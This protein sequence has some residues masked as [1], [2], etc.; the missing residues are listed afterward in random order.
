M[1]NPKLFDSLGWNDLP[2]DARVHW[3][4][5]EI[6]LLDLFAALYQPREK[7]PVEHLSDAQWN[8]HLAYEHAKAMLK[9]RERVLR[10]IEQP[11]TEVPG[12]AP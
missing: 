9:E 5:T 6:T 2:V 1:I 8:S 11:S 7:S 4:A 3:R 12:A 10:E